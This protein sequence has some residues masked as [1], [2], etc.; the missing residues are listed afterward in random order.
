MSVCLGTK[1]LP[2]FCKSQYYH[3]PQLHYGE[4]Y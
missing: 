3:V 2:A 1:P 4:C